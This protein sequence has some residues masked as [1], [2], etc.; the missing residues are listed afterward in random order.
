MKVK[1]LECSFICDDSE[2]LSADNPFMVSDVVN[3][4]PSCFSVD[5]AEAAC[6]EPDC[7]RPANCGTPTPDGYRHTCSA[8]RPG[9]EV[10]P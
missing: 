7:T 2:L 4:C 9:R 3:G 10:K 1:C 6:D 8:H 5:K